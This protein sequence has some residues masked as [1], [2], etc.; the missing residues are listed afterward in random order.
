M[1]RLLLASRNAVETSFGSSVP[2]SL[3]ET[4]VSPMK[5]IKKPD[6]VDFGVG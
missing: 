1:N 6:A 3:L 2:E 4:N 5:K